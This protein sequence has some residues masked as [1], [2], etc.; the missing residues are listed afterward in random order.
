M[1]WHHGP[2]PGYGMQPPQLPPEVLQ[3]V[4][5]LAEYRLSKG[6]AFE[7]LVREKHRS[8][9]RF[10]FL[11]DPSSPGH[12]YYQ[13][14]VAQ[15]QHQRAPAP[16]PM[17]YAPP[18][19]G[20][21][22]P[23]PHYHP[24]PY[25]PQPPFPTSAAPPQ[26]MY[27]APPPL[28]AVPPAYAPQL[29]PPPQPPQPLPPQPPPPPTLPPNT[30]APQ[31]AA[32]APLSALSMPVGV[33]ATILKQRERGRSTDAKRPLAFTPLRPDE[34]PRA[35]PSREPPQA[36]DEA[37]W[38]RG[39]LLSL[40][41]PPSRSPPAICRMPP[42]RVSSL[43]PRLS[44]CCVRM[45]AR[46]V[47]PGARSC[48]FAS[49]CRVLFPSV[50]PCDQTASGA[51]RRGALLRWRQARVVRAQG[52]RWLTAPS[53]VVAIS[54]AWPIE[55]SRPKERAGRWPRCC[56]QCRRRL[57]RPGDWRGLR[58]AARGGS[59]GGGRA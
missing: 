31:H 38:T 11:F 22:Q 23:P 6:D 35:L 2:H 15:L 43:A 59:R 44:P 33:L 52:G 18:P 34:I 41:P 32:G 26:H 57:L 10:A 20:Y 28:Q 55:R 30:A 56:S 53:S 58:A 27:G 40:R 49:S 36:F 5:H 16:P 24:G 4:E 29:P 17:A 3:A 14:R 48:L 7:A 13:A 19:V 54:A 37:P 51:R 12:A 39:A 21:A 42:L 9:P 45:H 1:S 25:M 46:A 50:P 47:H 8:D